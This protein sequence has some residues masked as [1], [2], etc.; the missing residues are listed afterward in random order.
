MSILIRK[1]N[2]E[3]SFTGIAKLGIVGLIVAFATSFVITIWAVY[4]DSFL[5]DVSKVGLI[6]S[7]LTLIGIVSYFVFIPFIEKNSK[8][9]IFVGTLII[10]VLS[11]FI[12]FITESFTIFL[13]TAF[14][15]TIV[16]T[17]RITSFGLIIKDKSHKK[18]LPRNEGLM[19]T[20]INISF[21][22]GPMLAGIISNKFGMRVIF[23]FASLF[24]LIAIFIFRIEKIKDNRK[25]KKVDKNL[26]K[27]FIE[28]FRNKDRVI[29]YFLGGGV[30]FWWILIYLFVPLYMVRNGLNNLWI[31]YFLFAIPLP[32]IF[33]EYKFSKM[34]RKIGFGKL[35]KIGFLIPAIVSLICFF[36]IDKVIIVLALLVI[37]SIGL[38]ML[39]PTT[40]AYF[41]DISTAKE[42]QRFYGPYNTR[43][44][45]FGF[46]GKLLP[47]LI[48][49]YFPLKYI[50]LMFSFA[51]F[52]FFLI[53]FKAKVLYG[54]AQN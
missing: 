13:I 26:M 37:A 42:E 14:V 45:I 12:L 41:F 20:F 51:M 52:A 48:L 44:E 23:F 21:I 5:N 10:F 18:N 7:L 8:S 53:S 22:I 25:Q 17:L 15:I 11:Y 38:A 27:N 1:Y 9:K 33:L 54:E 50:F 28:F 43:L 19:F 36:I 4:L 39:E 3:G 6:S 47:S 30:G 29:A 31:G 35:F 34:A 32:L 24:I 40:E 46:I 49:L 2:G 16:G